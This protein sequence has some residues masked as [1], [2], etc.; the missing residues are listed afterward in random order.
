MAS[1]THPS[2]LVTADD[3]SELHTMPARHVVLDLKLIYDDA[4]MA[5]IRQGFRPNN[6]DQKWFIYFTDNCLYLHRSW[7]GNLI[8]QI[9]F[10]QKDTSWQ[11]EQ[12]IANRDH[13]E[14]GNADDDQ[15]RHLIADIIDTNLLTQENREQVDG[16]LA[17]LTLASQ[18]NYLGSPQ[19]VRDVLTPLFANKVGWWLHLYAP[20]MPA[21]APQTIQATEVQV[22]N[23]FSGKDP[24]YTVM[25]WHSIE[26]LGQSAI[27]HFNLNADYCA[28]ES[29]FFVMFESVTAISLSIM[30]LLKEYLQDRNTQWADAIQQLHQLQ[31]FV[32]SVMLGTAA[33]THPGKTLSD[34]HWKPTIVED[35]DM[36][37]VVP[38]DPPT[39]PCLNDKGQTVS[40]KHPH[41]ASSEET[42]DDPEAIATFV[43]RGDS[44]DEI[45]GIACDSWIDPPDGEDWNEVEGQMEDLE[46]PPMQLPKPDLKPASGCV[47][48]EPD[49]RVWLVSPTDQFGG[50]KNTFPKGKSIDEVTWQANAIKEAFEESG[51]QVRIIG[52]IGDV[53]RTT[54]V[55]R[56]YRAVRIGGTPVDMGWESQAVHLVPID[57]LSDFLDSPYD[58][59]VIAQAYGIKKPA[60]KLDYTLAK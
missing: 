47:I 12:A 6:M 33:L 32:E 9:Q 18:P 4:Q 55:T 16:F 37:E 58:H 13:E 25:P 34:F 15:D 31:I 26:Q 59:Q 43:P 54:S 50:Y 40:I 27:I 3:W 17:A 29:L 11:A 20:S 60:K 42:W 35:D 41:T 14:W 36:D 51:L 30:T 2:Q 38:I 23:I 45:N 28:D 49:G 48:E 8:F 24:T 56:Y 21:V 44:P 57:K 10:A 22:A 39:H 1:T 52:L 7:T 53:E 19:V 5:A 46:D